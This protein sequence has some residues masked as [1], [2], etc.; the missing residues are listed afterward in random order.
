V[1]CLFPVQLSTTQLNPIPWSPRSERRSAGRP[2]YNHSGRPELLIQRVDYRYRY[3]V[4][5]RLVSALLQIMGPLACLQRSC[6]SLKDMLQ[7]DWGEG[8]SVSAC[9]KRLNAVVQS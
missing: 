5:L 8:F 2:H 1:I 4:G 7:A 6:S 3:M 9:L